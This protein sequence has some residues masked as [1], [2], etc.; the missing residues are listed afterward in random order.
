MRENEPLHGKL[1]LRRKLFVAT[2]EYLAAGKLTP[3]QENS[4]AV[5]ENVTL[6]KDYTGKFGY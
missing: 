1:F 6:H 2:Q 5:Q 3:A 4:V